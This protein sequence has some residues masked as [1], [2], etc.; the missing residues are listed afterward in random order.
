[1]NL[2]LKG[3][4]LFVYGLG[5]FYLGMQFQERAHQKQVEHHTICVPGPSE[6]AVMDERG[7]CSI[8]KGSRVVTRMQL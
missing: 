3:V 6:F 5:V 4:G 7:L 1:M 8:M 2:I